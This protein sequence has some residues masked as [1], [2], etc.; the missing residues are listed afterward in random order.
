MNRPGNNKNRNNKRSNSPIAL[1]GSKYDDDDDDAELAH[2]AT[3]RQE[4]KTFRKAMSGRLRE[5]R[6]VQSLWVGSSR[7]G[8]KDS[9]SHVQVSID[10]V[11]TRY[12]N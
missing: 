12:N 3:L 7:T 6:V 11:D 4:G 9:L 8:G 1:P 5:L 2:F 10:T